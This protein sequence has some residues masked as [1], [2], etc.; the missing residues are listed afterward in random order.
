MVGPAA[1][2]SAAALHLEIPLLNLTGT[3][4]LDTGAYHL[5]G[6]VEGEDG[7]VPVDVSAP[8]PRAMA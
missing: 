8:C 7:D 4:D 6:T 3:V 2:T 5:T 1:T